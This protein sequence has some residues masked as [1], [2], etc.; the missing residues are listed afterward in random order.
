MEIEYQRTD[1]DYYLIACTGREQN[2]ENTSFS[3]AFQDFNIVLRDGTA[4]RTN[5]NNPQQKPYKTL[6]EWRFRVIYA[7]RQQERTRQFSD[8]LDLPLEKRPRA[9]AR[10]MRQVETEELVRLGRQ[11]FVGTDSDGEDGGAAASGIREPRVPPEPILTGFS[12]RPIPVLD[13]PD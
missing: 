13:G 1:Y 11:I 12:T 10:L 9:L 2:R 4:L 6:S 8:V 7:A 3:K 5:Q